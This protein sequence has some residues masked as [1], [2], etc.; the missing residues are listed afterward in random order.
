MTDR[1]MVAK[2]PEVR[3]MLVPGVDEGLDELASGGEGVDFLRAATEAV[4]GDASA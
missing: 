1:V 4:L 2:A 3:Q